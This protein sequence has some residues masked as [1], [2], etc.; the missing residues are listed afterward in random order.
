MITI[1]FIYSKYYEDGIGVTPDFPLALEYFGKAASK[2]YQ[3]AAEKLNRPLADGSR[4]QKLKKENALN[5]KYLTMVASDPKVKQ[6]DDDDDE[7]VVNMQYTRKS[8]GGKNS[9]S[10]ANNSNNICTIQ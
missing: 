7:I 9:N 1:L 4:R 6:D 5:G 2:G 10:N 8:T 3:P